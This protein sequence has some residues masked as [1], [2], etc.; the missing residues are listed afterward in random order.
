MRVGK[1]N[2]S[3]AK[4][5]DYVSIMKKILVL[6]SALLVFSACKPSVKNETNK[7]SHNQKNIQTALLKYTKFSSLVSPKLAQA[8]EDWKKAEAI[9]SEEEKAEAM[10]AVNKQFASGI[11]NQLTQV[12][13]KSESID[14]GIK[15]VLKNRI[16]RKV[17]KKVNAKITSARKKQSEARGIMYSADTSTEESATVSTKKAISK[18]ISASSDV[19]SAK[20]LAKK[21]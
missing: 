7:W 19:N 18:L 20:K 2:L 11:M 5:R 13:Y 21:K 3:G 17:S 9:S 1:K 16:P 8:K 15:G 6:T 4:E 10:K 14:D 12:I